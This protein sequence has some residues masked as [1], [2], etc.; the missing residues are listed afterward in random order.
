MRH[1]EEPLVS[2][3]VPV[4]NAEHTLPR[5]L[6]SL[7]QQTLADCEIIAVDDGSEDRSWTLLQ[8]EAET[9]PRLK[10]HR[11][12][13][14]G[15][16][17]AR[18]LGHELAAGRYITF[19]DADDEVEPEFLSVLV[20]AIEEHHADI[21]IANKLVK[22]KGRPKPRPNPLKDSVIDN[23]KRFRATHLMSHVAP[24]GKL[25]RREFL[26][27]HSIRF[28]EGIT[29]EDHVHWVECLTKR[30][31]VGTSSQNVYTYIRNA[32]SISSEA[33]RLDAYNINSRIT[34]L[35][36]CIRRAKESEIKGLTAKLYRSQFNHS[37]LRHILAMPEATDHAHA[38]EAHALLKK[39]LKPFRNAIAR[40]TSG[41]RRMLYELVLQGD[42][43]D[44]QK[45]CR[46]LSGDE[47][48]PVELD[49]NRSRSVLYI[50]RHALPSLPSSTDASLFNVSD[51]LEKKAA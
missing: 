29:Y 20:R 1:S 30:P 8:Q 34:A 28:F 15:A 32:S 16:S 4:Y 19:V 35:T 51:V 33:R 46:F 5:C 3:V 21:A 42:N 44:L 6:S 14:G 49:R 43:A 10:I 47:A 26:E 36:E 12:Q 48:L 2:I 45:F 38:Q 18:N 9:E 23:Q 41:W 22:K 50:S 17:T 27:I 31:R 40:S 11:K 13:N 37:V 39:R 7:R 24:H 25:F